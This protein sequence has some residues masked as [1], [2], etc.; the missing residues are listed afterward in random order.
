MQTC[1]VRVHVMIELLHIFNHAGSSHHL[2]VPC[3]G[4]IHINHPCVRQTFSGLLISF[5]AYQSDILMHHT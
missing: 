5:S 3:K 2:A 1:Q 4:R